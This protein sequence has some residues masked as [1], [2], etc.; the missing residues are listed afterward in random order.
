MASTADSSVEKPVPSFLWLDEDTPAPQMIN[1]LSQIAHFFDQIGYS[2]AFSALLKEATKDGVSIDIAEWERGIDI[3]TAVPFL[4]LYQQWHDDNNGFPT[5]PRLKEF[6]KSNV[7][8]VDKGKSRSKDTEQD[9]AEGILMDVEAEETDDDG[10]ENQNEVSSDSDSSSASSAKAGT[11]RKRVLTPSSSD[12]SSSA[13]DGSDSSSDSSSDDAAPPAKKARVSDGIDTSSASDTHSDS[14]SSS[15]D[16][17]S[18]SESG[19]KSSSSSGTS[20]DSSSSNSES[21]N[22]KNTQKKTLPSKS[23]K[24]KLTEAGHKSKTQD[25]KGAGSKSEASGSR[26]SSTL[27]ADSAAEKVIHADQALTE[28]S[29]HPDRL[30]R[31]SPTK[32]NIAALRKNQIPFSRIS[33]SQQVD[34]RFASN[35][36]V[37]YDYADRAF[38]DLSVTKGKGFTK[39]K[40]KK[41]RG[42]LSSACS[43]DPTIGSRYA[44]SLAFE[45]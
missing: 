18:S 12:S 34:P 1:V 40:N 29:V 9:P 23:K 43:T 41:K 16:S 35:G 27:D 13:S 10:S 19:S 8:K 28:N 17:D 37:P 20:S 3:D 33:A 30:K 22:N 11:K 24:N 31:M 2:K 26:S 7:N 4:E 32:K 39:E 38:R 44:L 15:S 45:N 6:E 14:S 5:L 42:K 36:Y 25:L 21:E